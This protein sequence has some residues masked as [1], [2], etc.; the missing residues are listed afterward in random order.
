M[1]HTPNPIYENKSGRTTLSLV[2]TILI[3]GL[4]FLIIPLTQLS[5][6]VEDPE[7][8]EDSQHIY[9]TPPPD[10]P[11]P[12]KPPEPDDKPDEPPEMDDKPE[13]LT[14]EQIRNLMDPGH[15][16]GNHKVY[17]SFDPDAFETETLIFL[18][19]ELDEAPKSIITAAPVYP[20]EL[21]RA[22]IEGTV[23]VIYIV[24]TR[25]NVSN[26]RI[27]DAAHREFAESVRTSL[28]RWSFEPGRKDNQDVTTRV[29]QSFG[30]NLK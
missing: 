24:T 5:S 14:I 19:G 4:L 15:G 16:T 22:R 2:F 17:T 3:T 21:K 7:D 10:P 20:P 25:G 29:R 23:E 26:I 18:I 30:F 13:K 8:P 28:R 27:V 1:T 12:P 6:Q 9:M 11:E